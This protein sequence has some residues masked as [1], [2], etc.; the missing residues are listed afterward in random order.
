MGFFRGGGYYKVCDARIKDV[1]VGLIHAP[2]L[3]L[4]PP[5]LGWNIRDRKRSA[6]VSYCLLLAVALL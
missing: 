6:A 5:H 2:M 1:M 3:G 4:R